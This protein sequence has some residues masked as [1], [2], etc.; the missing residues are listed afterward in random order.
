MAFVGNS[1]IPSVGRP[2][3]RESP[4]RLKLTAQSS[5]DVGRLDNLRVK[6]PLCTTRVNV[7]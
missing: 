5:P 1:S 6:I 7:S 4:K 2:P 3:I